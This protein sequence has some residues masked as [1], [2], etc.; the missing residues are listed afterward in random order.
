[1]SRV[2]WTLILEAK[3]EGKNLPSSIITIK[4]NSAFQAMEGLGQIL[5][6]DINTSHLPKTGLDMTGPEYDLD[7]EN[8]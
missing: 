7:A 4:A 1:M 8:E 5:T 2:V 3:V 6:G